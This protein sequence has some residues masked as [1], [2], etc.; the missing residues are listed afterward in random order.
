MLGGRGALVLTARS[1]QFS[2]VAPYPVIQLLIRQ[3]LVMLC[4]RFGGMGLG[5]GRSLVISGK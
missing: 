2:E 4:G 1:G 5:E 3:P